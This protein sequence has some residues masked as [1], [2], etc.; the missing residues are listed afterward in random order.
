MQYRQKNSLDN[1]PR[2]PVEYSREP[3]KASGQS[4]YLQ[5]VERYAIVWAKTT[6]MLLK[7]W[8]LPMEEVDNRIL[9]HANHASQNGYKTT[10][11]VSEAKNVM[12]LCLGHCKT[13]NCPLYEKCGTQNRTRYV[14]ICNL[15]PLL[16]HDLCDPLVG[17]HA[18]SGCD[19]V[20][21][22]AWRGKTRRSQ[23]CNSWNKTFQ[24][25]FKS[26]GTPWDVSG[27]L[28][29]NMESFVCRMYAPIT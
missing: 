7:S 4:S 24:K 1:I 15:A 21:A 12:I 10:V 20:N 29:S 14:N 23:T 2:G 6:G 16:G 8:N 17:V 3:G 27:E 11:I 22:F 28:N 26:L 13:I 19:S 18:F 9:L 5:P 25:S